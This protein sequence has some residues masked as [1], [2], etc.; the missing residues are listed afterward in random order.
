[1]FD[2]RAFS[3]LVLDPKKKRLIRCLVEHGSGRTNDFIAGKGNGSIFLFHGPAGV[4]KT[5]T[6][7]AIAELLRR[8]LYSVS[9]G[10]LGTTPI[11]LERNLSQIL[12]VARC[13]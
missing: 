5:L 9:V 7:E 10:E 6:S 12:E 3:N 11:D 13:V 4:G 8:P 2:D 1:M